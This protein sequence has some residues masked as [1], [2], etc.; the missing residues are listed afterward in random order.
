MGFVAGL[1]D[2][3]G[4]LLGEV[5][6]GLGWEGDGFGFEGVEEGGL[7]WICRPRRPS[8]MFHLHCSLV[9]RGDM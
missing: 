2:V 1:A 6:W 5:D 3:G 7:G 4:V 9:G 8:P